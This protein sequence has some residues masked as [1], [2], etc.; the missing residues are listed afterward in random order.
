MFN[1]G[2]NLINL[3]PYLF[4]NR[5]MDPRLLTDIFD[6]TMERMLREFTCEMLDCLVRK[7][8]VCKKR[9]LSS[10][11]NASII[12]S[13][14]Y[15]PE[16]PYMNM[17]IPTYEEFLHDIYFYQHQLLDIFQ[18]R[19]Q[20]LLF[21]KNLRKYSME[22]V[23]FSALMCGFTS[24]PIHPVKL[25]TT[26]LSYFKFDFRIARSGESWVIFKIDKEGDTP[27]NELFEN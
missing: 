14:G 5:L 26:L 4:D 16:I 7:K 17:T 3:T 22:K 13:F 8:R 11:C 1:D 27:F 19:N 24:F 12:K 15:D 2:Q 20:L 9:L 25:C 6:F 23:I 21:G 18:L 10:Q